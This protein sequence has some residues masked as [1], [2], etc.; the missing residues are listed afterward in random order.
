MKRTYYLAYGMNTNLDSMKSRCPDAISLG[1][2]WLLDHELRFKHFCDIEQNLGSMMECALWSITE[3]CERSLDR[4][5]GYPDFYLKK[6]VKVKWN[7]KNIIAMIYYMADSYH[8]YDFP[9][10]YYFSTVITGYKQ[11]EMNLDSLYTA[12]DFV[13][14]EKRHEYSMG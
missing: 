9:S 12:L 5:E 6:E 14:K 3:A 8:E 7:N 13:V 10:E 11:H 2:V 4:L 1:K